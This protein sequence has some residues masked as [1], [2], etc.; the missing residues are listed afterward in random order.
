[1]EI[2][3]GQPLKLPDG[4][5]VLPEV[6]AS[7]SKVVSKD[8]QE[9]QKAQEQVEQ[10][11]NTLLE[12]P[13]HNE[14][15]QVFRRTL[16][17]INEDFGKMNVIMLCVS[18][19]LWGLDSYAISRLMNVTPE[20]IDALMMSD[21]YTRVHKE[22]IEAMRYAEAATVHGY[23]TAKSH[24]AAR[25]VASTLTNPSGDLRLAAAKDI[26][27]RSGFRPVDRVE[28]THRFEDELRIRYVQDTASMPTLDLKIEE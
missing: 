9:Q 23:L 22:L 24:A 28:H 20:Q 14:H 13:V 21:S 17:D 6:H 19:A 27:D 4:T 12:D 16:A 26:L 18:Y 25:V 7:G 15:G 5:I 1:M 11:L 2:V 8:E 10:E 3:K